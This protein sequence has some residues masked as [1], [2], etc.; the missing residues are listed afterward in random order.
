MPVKLRAYIILLAAASV[1][2]FAFSVSFDKYEFNW[3]AFLFFSVLVFLAENFCI[4]LPREGAVSVS[5]TII[6][7]SIVLFGPSLAVPSSAFAA[8]IW[9]DIKKGTH[10]FRWVFN[11]S[12]Y[13]LAAGIG[14]TVYAATG[15]PILSQ[16]A[17]GFSAAHFP[18][19]LLPL[20]LASISFFLTN[21]ALVSI[22]IGLAQKMSPVNVWLINL[23]W[24]SL[25]YLALAPLGVAMA[26]TYMAA[27]YI[28]VILIILPMIVARQTFQI[29]MRLRNAYMNTVKSLIVALEAKDRYTRGHS[30]RVAGVADK[31][32]RQ[33]KLGEN[34]LETLR[35]AGILHDIGKVGTAR[36][37]LRKPGRL[38][39]DE[40]QRIKLHPEA[41]AT[42]LREIKFLHKVVPIIF[43]HH[44]HFDGSGY[45][46]GI[47][48]PE[49][50]LL[51]RILTVAD[52]YD[53]MT[54]PRPYQPQMSQETACRELIA[55]SGTQ[56]DP[57]VVQAFLSAINYQGAT[58]SV[59]EGQLSLIETTV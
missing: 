30:E 32:G 28:G 53:A 51:A 47:K 22:V 2:M 24:T 23:R 44:E 31:I 36:Y 21:T 1:G 40:F 49:I 45:I 16:S 50:P 48:G 58:Q 26:Q 39:E 57:Q 33:L 9:R 35:Y 41:G 18:F 17:N 15:G 59:A 3:Q 55:C 19:S 10:P 56:F 46:D 37:I 14:G 34:E 42:I 25:N 27:G 13:A 43:H 7:A 52:A 38:T 54:S 11:G 29:F 5:F 8:F 6:L 12:Q 4:E 20:A